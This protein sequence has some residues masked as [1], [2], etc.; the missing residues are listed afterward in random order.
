MLHLSSDVADLQIAMST[1]CSAMTCLL[2]LA[3][4]VV[5][6]VDSDDVDYDAIDTVVDSIAITLVAYLGMLRTVRI[7]YG[8]LFDVPPDQEDAGVR[9]RTSSLTQLN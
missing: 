9:H 3:L 7:A 2:A 4:A 1:F 5:A 8:T 6:T